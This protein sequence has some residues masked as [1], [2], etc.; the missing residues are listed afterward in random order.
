[1]SNPVAKFARKYNKSAVHTDRKKQSKKTGKFG[2]RSD[3]DDDFYDWYA[4]MSKRNLYE[5]Y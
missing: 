4:P 5:E 1:M 3:L 2:G